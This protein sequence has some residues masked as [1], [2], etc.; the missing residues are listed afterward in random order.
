MD[1][2]YPSG[3]VHF[4]GSVPLSSSEEVFTKLSQAL[5]N[6]LASI[7]DGET[8]DRNNYIGWER[9]RFPR[10]TRRLNVGGVPL[11]E[12]HFAA[13]TQDDV[14]PTNYDSA[15]KESYAKFV[16]LRKKGVIPSGVRFQVSI[17]APYESIQG[18]VRAE[19]QA[20]LEPFYEKRVFDAL[21]S[22]LT[23]I[24]ADDLA[25]QFDMCFAVM[26]L[27]YEMGRLSDE[28]FRPYFSP[29]RK[30]LLERLHRLHEQ[31][32]GTVPLGWHFCYGDLGH[33]HFVQ[34]KDMTLMVD[35][36][37][38]LARTVHSR[39]V[40]WVHMPVPKSRDDPGYFK[41][42]EGLNTGDGMKLYL[43]LVHANDEEGTRRR[44]AAARTVRNNFGV[45]T[46]CGIGRTPAEELES[47]LQISKNVTCPIK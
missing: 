14:Q 32:P 47:I 40:S 20:C 7:P 35:F 4:V 16:D 25:I 17:P 34:P 13:F 46:E 2:S 26:A 27:E 31:I 19:W 8:G 30:G 18:H 37:N 6:R 24:P 3:G 29:I 43:G 12:G 23:S 41:A 10:E 9:E 33:K 21:Q 22:I 42:L 45:A 11:P 5:P 38:E 28:L 44:I 1:Q 36:A 39:P 15:A